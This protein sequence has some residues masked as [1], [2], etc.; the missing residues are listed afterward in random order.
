MIKPTGMR[1]T[2]TQKKYPIKAQKYPAHHP[3]KTK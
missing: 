2:D 3:T 1:I